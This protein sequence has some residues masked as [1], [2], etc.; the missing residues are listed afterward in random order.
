TM[1]R[2]HSIAIGLGRSRGLT[3]TAKCTGEGA[4]KAICRKSEVFVLLGKTGRDASGPPPWAACGQDLHYGGA[5][6]CRPGSADLRS[7]RA[8]TLK[9]SPQPHSTFALGF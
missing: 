7:A 1:D 8:Q 2:V 9:L 3:K 6:T 4:L 5:G